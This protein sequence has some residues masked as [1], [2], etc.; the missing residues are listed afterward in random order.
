MPVIGN[1]NAMVGLVIDLR[2][3]G[4]VPVTVGRGICGLVG[5][6]TRGPANEAIALGMPSSARSLYYSGDLKEA[7]ETAFNQGCPVIYAVRVLGSG[8]AKAQ[9]EIN[10]GL[11]TPQ[12]CG[13]ISASSEG[14]WGNSVVRE[15]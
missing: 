9:I 11:T 5:T 7:I 2:T 12:V 15:N 1:Q 10:D 4:P 14:I 8:N 13:I 3:I 6:S